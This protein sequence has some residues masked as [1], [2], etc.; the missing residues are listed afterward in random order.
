MALLTVRE[1]EAKA[2]KIMDLVYYEYYAK[3]SDD[4]VTLRDNVEAFKR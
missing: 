4:E 2:A 3:G 1:Y